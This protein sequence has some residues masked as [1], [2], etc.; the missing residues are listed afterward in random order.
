MDTGD[1]LCVDRAAP[2]TAA[3]AFMVMGE[4]GY[5]LHFMEENVE[6]GPLGDTT[7][8]QPPLGDTT[9]VTQPVRAALGT[10]GLWLPS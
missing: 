3:F 2:L 4:R 5:L 1:L 10:C 8:T 9:V 6:T 7:V